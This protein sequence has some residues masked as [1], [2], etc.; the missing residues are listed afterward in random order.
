MGSHF[1]V[2]GGEGE[3]LLQV[4][5]A[6]V[7]FGEVA[8]VVDSLDFH[9]VGDYFL[10]KYLPFIAKNGLALLKLYPTCRY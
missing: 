3:G 9:V 10:D 1:C 2:L 7:E 6:E 4:Q 5:Q 8:C